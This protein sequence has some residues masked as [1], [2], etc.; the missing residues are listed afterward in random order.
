MA[1]LENH[2]ALLRGINVGGRNKIPMKELVAA[3]EDL[4]W[5]NVRTHLQTGNVL[6]HASAA[7]KSLEAA[8]E[9]AIQTRFGLNTPVMLCD[10]TTLEK[11]VRESPFSKEAV[12]EPGRVLLYLAKRKLA[13][14]LEAELASRA[15][16]GE[17]VAVASARALWAYY[18]KGVGVSKLTPAVLDRAAG[19]NV[20]GRNWNTITRLL[21][22]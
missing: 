13:T 12:E 21:A 2:L 8:L 1:A 18:P 16:H 20:T 3:C 11:L 19:G 14:D 6:F 7:A 5:T 17:Q 4:G 22:M 9:K 15:K 10:L